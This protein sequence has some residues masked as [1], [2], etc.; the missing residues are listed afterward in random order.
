[1]CTEY[2]GVKT[3]SKRRES[4]AKWL[5]AD[6]PGDLRH[7]MQHFQYGGKN[8]HVGL[9]CTSIRKT[10]LNTLQNFSGLNFCF[11]N[12]TVNAG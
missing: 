10:L 8:K 1:M 5:F 11:L 9:R 6:F 3:T 2:L 7:P 4:T 12:P